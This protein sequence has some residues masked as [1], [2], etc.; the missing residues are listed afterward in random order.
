VKTA[1]FPLGQIVATPGGLIALTEAGHTP[2]EFIR[3]HEVG[4]WG[5]L[6]EEDRRQNERSLE[7]RCRLLSAYHLRD[8]TNIWIITEADRSST[9]LLLP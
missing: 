8:G 7:D 5:D 2:Q 1:R 6:D 9:T 3:R 4:D